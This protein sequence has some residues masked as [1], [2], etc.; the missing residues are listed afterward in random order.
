MGADFERCIA[1]VLAHEGGYTRHRADRGNWTG[2]RVGVGELKGTKYGIAANTYP[3][4]DIENL[5]RDEAVAIYRRDF[6]QPT[7]CDDLPAVVRFQL[8]DAAVNHGIGRAKRLLQRAV[9]VREDG[10]IGPVTLA[11]VR[12]LDPMD[13]LLRLCAV[14]IRFYADLPDFDTFGRGWTR[15]MADNLLYAAEDN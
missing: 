10:V 1:R 4:L 13:L 15:R 7:R 12:A 5:T 9:G 6:W 11:A 8:L 2:G 14:R 3:D